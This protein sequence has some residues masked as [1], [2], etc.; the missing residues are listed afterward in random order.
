[1]NDRRLERSV[2]VVAYHFPP[3]ASAA[4]VRA[5]QLA[6][7]LAE[8]EWAVRVLHA[9]PATHDARH[10]GWAEM[11]DQRGIERF[12]APPSRKRLPSVAAGKPFGSWAMSLLRRR[13]STAA[14]FFADWIETA[15][16]AA[17]RILDEYPVNIVLGIAPPLSAALAAEAIARRWQLPL[18]VDFGEI[19][20]LIPHRTPSYD[21]RNHED[22]VEQLL[23]SAQYASVISRR[24]KELLL[25]RCDFLTH[26]EIGILP[27]AEPMPSNDRHART[28]HRQLLLVGEEL[29]MS[30][31]RP[32]L[33]V[34]QNEQGYRLRIAGSLPPSL[35]RLLQKWQLTER[36]ELDA[37]VTLASLDRW[38]EGSDAAVVLA[39]PQA[40]TPTAVAWR[41]AT[42]GVPILAVGE[43]ASTLAE[44]L[45][46]ESVV[47]SRSLD[48]KSMRAA[49]EKL[50]SIAP[51]VRQRDDVLDREFSR[52]LG[53][54]MKL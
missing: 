10:H 24:Q 51:A 39:T 6:E 13:L 27:H 11:L 37:T 8:R 15:V 34:L 52:R 31:L 54:A 28:S 42:G 9:A 50:C 41:I 21:G 17:A 19:V 3:H 44:E 46:P 30:V 36:V 49:I 4:S 33:K 2:L 26:E 43:Y 25:R 32:L 12:V 47:V 38:I 40:T 45:P 1:M 16:A 20:E 35:P 18:A 29:P 7:L 23:R 5:V 48:P 53:M 22:T 14:D